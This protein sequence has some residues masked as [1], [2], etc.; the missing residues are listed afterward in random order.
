MC[1]RLIYIVLL[2]TSVLCRHVPN[3]SEL[4]ED[5]KH[6][7]RAAYDEP[8]AAYGSEHH[9]YEAPAY[10]QEYSYD[11]DLQPGKL[12][13][14]KDGLWALKA[15]IKELKAFNKALA[16][17]MLATK[18]SIKDMLKNHLITI[19]KHHHEKPSYPAPSYAPA[20]AYPQYEAPY[21]P[22]PPAPYAHDPYAPT[23]Q[24]YRQHDHG[25]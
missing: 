11:E 5:E 3:F 24:Q 14:L 23:V 6:L 18:L 19:K 15:K 12:D 22:A 7:F 21:V 20:P 17:N 2:V 9:L 13:L 8:A 10:N 25:H 1:L 16:A 4:D